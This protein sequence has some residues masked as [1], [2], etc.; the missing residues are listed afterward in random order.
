MSGVVVAVVLSSI[1]GTRKQNLKPLAY[2]RRPENAT[3]SPFSCS[4]PESQLETRELLYFCGS[5]SSLK[6]DITK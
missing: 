3:E 1:N 4:E 6:S 5:Y 2:E